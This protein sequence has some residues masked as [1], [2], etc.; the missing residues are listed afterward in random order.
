[1][2]LTDQLEQERKAEREQRAEEKRKA[3][4]TDAK[5]L[6]ADNRQREINTL[7]QR[8]EWLESY[9]DEAD[10]VRQQLRDLEG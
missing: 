9:A 2:K 4:Q 8:L 5:Q 3:E 6:D 7:R 1:V 10:E